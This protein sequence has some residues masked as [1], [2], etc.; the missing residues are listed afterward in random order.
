ML[1]SWNDKAYF[2]Y[3]IFAGTQPI[4]HFMGHTIADINIA[5]GLRLMEIARLSE[6]RRKTFV[7]G[8]VAVLKKHPLPS[9]IE[10]VLLF[11]PIEILGRLLPNRKYD[12]PTI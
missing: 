7:S 9:K 12:L 1:L 3:N 2:L 6:S 10:T 11:D 4:T 5:K 8:V